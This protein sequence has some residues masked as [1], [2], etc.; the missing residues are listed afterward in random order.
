MKRPNSIAMPSDVLYQSVFPLNPVETRAVVG[1]G[2]RKGIKHLGES[3]RPRIRDGR[4]AKAVQNRNRRKHQ[5]HQ[6]KDQHH[7]HCHLHVVGFDLLPQIFRRAPHHQSRNKYR[8]DD[9]DQHSIHP[10]T[11]SAEDH[12]TQHEIYQRNHS[13]QWRERVVHGVDRAATRVGGHGREQCR[14]R[15]AESHLFPFEVA[16]ALQ[17]NYRMLRAMLRGS[18]RPKGY[19]AP[20]P[21]MRCSLPLGTAKPS[22]PI[23]PIHVAAS[24]SSFPRC[25]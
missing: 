17:C 24:R 8:K 2:G 11:N 18:R 20:P 7:Q 3:V 25:K 10:R 1:H 19:L 14:V 16:R 23:P 21:N 13:A 9:E 5:N 22:L 6:R 12:L 15:H 4:S